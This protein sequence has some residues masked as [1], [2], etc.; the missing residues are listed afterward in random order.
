MHRGHQAAPIRAHGGG[1]VSPAPEMAAIPLG[2]LPVSVAGPPGRAIRTAGIEPE[3]PR[4]AREFTRDTLQRWDLWPVYPDA[5]VVVSE[6]V[7]NA[8]R[9]GLRGAAVSAAPGPVDLTLWSREAYLIC[10]VADPNPE[11]PVLRPPD[12]AAEAGRGLQVVQAL[13]SS[14]GWTVRGGPQKVV[15]AALELP[16]ACRA[17]TGCL[18]GTKAASLSTGSA[19]PGRRPGVWPAGCAA[20]GRKP[21]AQPGGHTRQLAAP[22]AEAAYRVRRPTRGGG[23]C[24]PRD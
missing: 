6:L 15:W 8:L 10:V 21:A 5:A 9:Y 11:P 17:A 1:G 19:G 7:T 13:T 16:A 4:A 12:S 18:P 24:Q 22:A 2:L 20:T 14:W 3:S 23:R